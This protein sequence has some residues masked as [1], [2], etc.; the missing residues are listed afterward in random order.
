M[1]EV[2]LPYCPELQALNG[3]VATE[4]A[5]ISIERESI[6]QGAGSLHEV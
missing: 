3:K 5:G 1:G 4:T 2:E 6:V